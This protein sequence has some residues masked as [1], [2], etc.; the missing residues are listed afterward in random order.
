V[1]DP[2]EQRLIETIGRAIDRY[3]TALMR[4]NYLVVNPRT[5]VFIGCGTFVRA[6]RRFGILTAH[7]IVGELEAPCSLGLV[8]EG[9]R[10]ETR[11]ISSDRFSVCE[12]AISDPSEVGHDLAFI[13]LSDADAERIAATKCF[14]DL[15]T[16]RSK[17]LPKPLGLREGA[18]FIWGASADR[19][20]IEWERDTPI[21]AL[22]GLAG[23]G[24]ASREYE[25]GELDYIDVE[26]HY[27]E[28]YETPE[29]FRGYSGGG[30]WQ[31]RIEGINT[32]SP[33]PTEYIYSGV[34]FYQSDVVDKKR[35]LHCHG[36]RSVYGYAYNRILSGCG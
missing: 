23:P 27:G 9:E 5:D 30:L 29:D 36:R 14:V 33:T 22:H 1:T 20:T 24:L 13:Q 25:E 18:W 21:I 31:V 16:G 7:H 17:V 28:S 19:N 2:T 35:W 6:D 11:V 3:S 32:D 10:T 15:S 34:I 8:L 4:F 12:L 26:V